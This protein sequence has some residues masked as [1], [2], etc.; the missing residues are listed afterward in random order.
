MVAAVQIQFLHTWAYWMYCAFLT[1]A[2]VLLEGSFALSVDTHRSVQTIDSLRLR[3]ELIG[4]GVA[5]IA[6]AVVVTIQG[7]I[8]SRIAPGNGEASIPTT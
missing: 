7:P 5:L 8:L 3:Y 4:I 2:I 1:A 6:Q